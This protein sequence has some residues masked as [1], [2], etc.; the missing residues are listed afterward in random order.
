MRLLD[1]F[2]DAAPFL[3]IEESEERRRKGREGKEG[4]GKRCGDQRRGRRGRGRGRGTTWA[5][6]AIRILSVPPEVIAPHAPTA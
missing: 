1:A 3:S 2:H 4:R 5:L 6:T